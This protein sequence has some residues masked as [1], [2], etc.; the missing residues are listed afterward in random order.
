M[1][2]ENIQ[3]ITITDYEI[4]VAPGEITDTTFF[5][6]TATAS[7]FH[8]AARYSFDQ[9]YIE[10]LEPNTTYT[11]AVRAKDRFGNLSGLSEL[12]TA[13]TWKAAV[14]L[15]LLTLILW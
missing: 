3:G 13:T 9:F 4:L 6:S 8:S 5:K 2:V 11:I 12:F 7:A 15:I 1:L 10:N 14:E